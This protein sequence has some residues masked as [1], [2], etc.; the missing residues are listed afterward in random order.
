MRPFLSLYPFSSFEFSVVENTKQHGPESQGELLLEEDE[1]IF[2]SS[3]FCLSAFHLLRASLSMM[4]KRQHTEPMEF[5]ILIEHVNISAGFAKTRSL[6]HQH[7]AVYLSPKG[8][9]HQGQAGESH[10]GE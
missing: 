10:T 8:G 6:G 1:S 3:I 7:S 5:W 4:E 2:G 9:Y